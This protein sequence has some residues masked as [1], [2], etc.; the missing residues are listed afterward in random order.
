MA[1]GKYKHIIAHPGDVLP[2]TGI[3]VKVIT[4][5]GSVI[6]HALPGAGEKNEYCSIAENRPLDR[7]ENPHSLGVLITFVK[8]RILD[9]GD[10]TWDKELQLMCPDNRIGH[11][12]ILVVSHHGLYLSSTH[13][14]VDGLHPRVAIMNNG[15]TKGG[16][17]RTIDLVRQSPG[18]EALWQLHYSDR[19]G[20][21]HNTERKYIAN[22]DDPDAGNYLL[23]TAR[24]DGSF[25][26]FNPRD[27][28]TVSYAVKH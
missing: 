6:D 23:L 16:D 18:L 22:L 27:K 12:D 11:V 4:S 21:A 19:G 13:A 15:A 3:N 25:D 2:V 24:N 20:E 28:A 8:L 14:L 5:D 26:I 17:P 9:L 7:S 10:L 1:E